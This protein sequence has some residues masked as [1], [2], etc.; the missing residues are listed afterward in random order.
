MLHNSKAI[1]AKQGSSVIVRVLK[2]AALFSIRFK[3]PPDRLCMG[4]VVPDSAELASH[5]PAIW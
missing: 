3:N 4:A 5:K 2:Y 1:A